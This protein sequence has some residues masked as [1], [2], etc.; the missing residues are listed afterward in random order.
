MI[1]SMSFYTHTLDLVVPYLSTFI[2]FI[3]CSPT[4]TTSVFPA[5]FQCTLTFFFHST[6]HW[7]LH[8]SLFSILMGLFSQLRLLLMHYCKQ[9]LAH[10]LPLVFLTSWPC[11]PSTLVKPTLGLLYACIWAANQGWKIQ[12]SVDWLG[13]LLQ[14]HIWNGCSA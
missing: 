5:H 2:V 14:P 8:F 13:L 11:K 6:H 9:S 3:S 12:C 1:S 7:L 10:I 4:L